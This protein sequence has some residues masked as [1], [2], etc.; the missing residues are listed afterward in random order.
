MMKFYQYKKMCALMLAGTMT[1]G[2]SVPAFAA[3]KKQTTVEKKEAVDVSAPMTLEEIQQ[4]VLKN[5][6]LKTTLELNLEKITAGLSAISD[7]LKDIQDTQDDAAHARRSASQS[8]WQGNEAL[9][10][11]TAGTG[12]LGLMGEPIAAI[13]VALGGLAQIESG[14]LS[15][16]VK[17]ASAME[18]M[19][20]SI[21]EQK[22][23]ELK[24]QERDLKNKKQD[25]NK[26]KEDWNNEAL[27]VTQLLV[28][29][30]VQ[31]EKGIDLLTQKQALLE[32][33]CK[34][35]EK[36][37]ALGLSVSTD[38]AQKKLDVAESA[39]SLQ[40][41][42]DGLTLLKRQL[43]DL[44]GRELDTELHITAPQLTRSIET[45]PVYS[46][47]LLKQA[48]DKNYKLKTLERD[49]KQAEKDSK[50]SSKYAG[51]QQASRTDMKLADVSV[52]DEKAAIANDL[53]KKLDRINGAAAVYQNKKDANAKAKTQWE[54]Y[55]VSA[56]LGMVSA[57]E[58]QALQLQYEQTEME[59]SEAAYDYDMAWA[60]YNMLMDGTTLDIYETYKEKIG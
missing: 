22:R 42:K 43:N 38:V 16:T 27:A 44:M 41:A 34:I 15:G 30:S 33:V 3:E 7:G 8:A 50:D 54:Q 19:V 48:T 49:K 45:A 31:V 32:R 18:D 6:R 59:L 20:D 35:E 13:G 11:I 14:L 40:D 21:A 36:K 2:M 53:K 4:Q 46:E 5:N 12:Q 55:Q 26:T 17:T 24:T 56:K 23:D 58:L 57:V 28:T 10:Q 29:K 60:E 47:D 39:K 9:G 51:Q 1:A 37:A 25:L 52:E